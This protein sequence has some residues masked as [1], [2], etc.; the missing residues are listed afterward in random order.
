MSDNMTATEYAS[1]KGIALALGVAIVA[2][3]SALAFMPSVS[4]DDPK[5]DGE[6]DLYGY[7]VVMMLKNPSQVETVE[8]DFGDGSA[9]VTVT[10]DATNPNG[11]VEHKY[12]AKGD[13]VVT[14]TMR[15]QYTDP[16]TGELKPGET[17]L[18]YLYHILGFP[19][20]TFDSKGGSPVPTIEGT[21]SHYVPA[22]PANPTRDGFDFKGW[23]EDEGCTRPFDWSSEVTKHTTL[24]AGWDPVPVTEYTFTLRYDANGGTG[25][26][27]DDTFTGTSPD[28]H[29]FTVASSVPVREG[30]RFDGWADTADATTPVYKAGDAVSVEHGQTKTIHAVWL[31]I[32]VVTMDAPSTAVIGTTVML[33]FTVNQYRPAYFHWENATPG[34]TSK[35]DIIVNSHYSY[36]LTFTALK[37]GTFNI[38]LV[39]EHPGCVTAE[40]PVTIEFLPT[41]VTAPPSAEGIEAEVKE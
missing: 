32:L 30:F 29:V 31:K 35:A 15:N 3:L 8:W 10:L 33:T 18:T 20:V 21:S 34:M 14:A 22:K 9:H 19:I 16:V 27:A 38:T 17:K 2:I 6:L 1:R 36:T 13:Y 26:P 39:V 24:Y 37:V 25:A 41:D 12:A 5:Y 40:H 23:Y 4:A 28:A 11:M 7:E